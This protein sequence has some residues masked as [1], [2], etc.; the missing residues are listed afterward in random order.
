[1]EP[2]WWINQKEKKC[3]L[4]EKFLQPKS[5]RAIVISPR[6]KTRLRVPKRYSNLWKKKKK[7][8]EIL[9]FLTNLSALIN[10]L[11]FP[12]FKKLCLPTSFSDFM[13]LPIKIPKQAL[14]LRV[15]DAKSEKKRR[16]AH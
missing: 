11:P 1:M 12:D 8:H 6:T 15:T 7:I 16:R 3:L 9:T 14:D 5:V 4:E 13:N 10:V 2:L